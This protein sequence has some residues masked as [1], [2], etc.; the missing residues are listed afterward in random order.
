MLRQLP[1]M[2]DP[3]LIVGA[4]TSDDAGVYRLD[5]RHALVL[6]ADFLTPIVD[7]PLAFG[8]IAA[9][10][11]LSDVYAMGGRPLTALNLMCLPDEKLPPDIAG[12]VLRGGAMKIREAGCLLVGG[13]TMRNPELVYGLSVTGVVSPR[14]VLTND[15]ARPGDFLVLTKPLGTGVITT[16]IRRD[17]SPP[18]LV[19]KAVSVMTRLNSVGAELGESRLAHAATDVTGFGLL[20]HLGSMCKASAVGAE[21]WADAVPV[22]AKEVFE[23]IA[24]GCVSAGSRSNLLAANEVAEWA[25]DIRA[26]QKTLLTDAQTSG[27]LLLSVGPRRLEAV[28]R[29]LKQ[30][31][32]PCAAVIGRIVRTRKPVITIKRR[33]AGGPH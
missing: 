29:L 15:N 18:A 9:A 12:T 32:T 28:Q 14:R 27:G 21:L 33:A 8:Q 30:E 17:L 16:G 25:S 10:N 31:R 3:K 2:R 22:I 26:E 1:V 19:K 5:R 7:D 20:G 6:T 13:H 11:S 4:D 23:L 24:Q